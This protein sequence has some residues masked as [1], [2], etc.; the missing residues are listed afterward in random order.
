MS[1]RFKITK[2]KITDAKL[3][4]P[5][6]T[7]ST[8]DIVN[9]SKQVSNEF[10]RS[11]YWK[12]FEAKSAKGIDNGTDMYELLSVSFQ[13]VKRLFVLAYDATGDDE[14]GIK[15][16]KRCFIPRAEI[17]NYNVLIDGKISMINQLIINQLTT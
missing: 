6:V 16:N 9:L 1:W 11:V 17:K 5:I 4:V 8:E 2:L 15:N 7:L 14:A 3:Y 10:K 13:G 12:R